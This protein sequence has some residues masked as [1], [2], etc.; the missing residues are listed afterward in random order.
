MASAAR[1]LG[2]S[3]LTPTPE[4]FEEVAAL[5]TLFGVPYLVAPGEAEAQCAWLNAQGLVDAVATDDSDAFAFGAK[6]VYRRLFAE[7]EH[8][9]EY[10]EE[11]LVRDLGLSRARVV[12]LAQLLGSDYAPGVRGVGVV[13]AAEIV[14]VFEGNEGLE[15]FREWARGVGGDAVTVAAQMTQQ[16]THAAKRSPPNAQNNSSMDGHKRDNGDH[17]DADEHT[18]QGQEASGKPQT[19][20]KSSAEGTDRIVASSATSLVPPSLL[21]DHPTSSL[22]SLRL[23]YC[24]EHARARRRWEFPATFP[25]AEVVAEYASPRVDRSLRQTGLRFGFPAAEELR[26]F[27]RARLGWDDREACAALGPALAGRSA[28]N[29]Q[30]TL[31]GH[32]TFRKRFAQYA[33]VRLARAVQGIAGGGLD[34]KNMLTAHARAVLEGEGGSVPPR[35]SAQAR[36]GDSDEGG[37][38]RAAR[39][40]AGGRTRARGARR[41]RGRRA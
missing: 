23:S 20:E 28:R 2:P 4:M 7:R 1:S 40:R 15:A 24:R 37:L 9:E 38:S 34:E 35:Q 14:R 32:V 18:T 25:D 22:L 33:S 6:R 16:R 21:L 17:D 41:G 13:N 30:T 29:V 19:S 3:S 5:L 36:R 27:A 12:D 11:D 10:R 26:A 8:L 31:D 39:G